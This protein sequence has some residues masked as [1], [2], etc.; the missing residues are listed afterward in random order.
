VGEERLAGVDVARRGWRSGTR[1]TV[2]RRCELAIGMACRGCISLVEATRGVAR[3]TR[4]ARRVLAL[5]VVALDELA[6]CRAA[7]LAWPG[8]ALPLA[9]GERYAL[10]RGQQQRV[11]A[12]HKLGER[13]GN[14]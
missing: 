6:G 11:V 5:R 8:V 9:F 7:M 12:L 2:G 1:R 3:R 4:R 10:G 13:G 14:L